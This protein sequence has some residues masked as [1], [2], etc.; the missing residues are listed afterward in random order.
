MSN[1]TLTAEKTFNAK[2]N[3]LY[4]AWTEE[5]ALKE[6]WKPAGKKLQSLTADLEIGG[7]LRYQFEKDDSGNLVIE[8]TYEEVVSEEKL[9]YTWNWI[10]N[11]TPVEDGEYKLTIEF[12]STEEGSKLNVGQE[13]RSAK[14]GIHPNQEGWDAALEDLENYLSK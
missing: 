10:L 4:K 3:D 12:S 13:S 8:G 14:E 7:K 11:D 6:W 2:V 1:A 5:S 9:I